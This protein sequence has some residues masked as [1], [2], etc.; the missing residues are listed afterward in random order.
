MLSCT[1]AQS[2]DERSHVIFTRTIGRINMGDVERSGRARLVDRVFGDPGAMLHNLGHVRIFACYEFLTLGLV[3][4]GPMPKRKSPIYGRMCSRT[5][6]LEAGRRERNFW[7]RRQRAKNRRQ[8]AHTS[9]ET[10]IR[11]LIGRKSPQKRPIWRLIG[12]VRFA[13]TGWWRRS[14]SNCLLPTQGSNPSPKLEPGTEFFAAETGRRN[15]PIHPD[16]GSRD[17][18]NQRIWQTCL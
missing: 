2:F 8:N 1:G 5:S 16:C 15:G 3:E 12:N 10:K 4:V 17:R 14:G 18:A 9:T 13:E 6:A 11:E 7:M